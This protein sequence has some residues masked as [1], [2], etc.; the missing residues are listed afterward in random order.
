MAHR[1]RTHYPALHRGRLRIRTNTELRATIAANTPVSAV[2]SRRRAGSPHKARGLTGPTQSIKLP[3]GGRRTMPRAKA[4]YDEK[5][6]KTLDA[7][8]HIRL[9]SGMSIVRAAH[10]SQRPGGAA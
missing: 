7:L 1:L 8:E 4:A 3:R 5:T 6:I 9:R 2:A 10:G